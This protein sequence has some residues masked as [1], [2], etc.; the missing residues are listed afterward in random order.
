[1]NS[2]GKNSGGKNSGGKNSG[3]T[4]IGRPGAARF[5]DATQTR[6][7]PCEAS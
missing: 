2:G 6:K 5:E 3:G 7:H 1:M 4:Q